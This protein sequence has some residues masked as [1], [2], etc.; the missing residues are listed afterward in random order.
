MTE[1]RERIFAV[2]WL[3]FWEIRKF[4][5]QCEVSKW[6]S[7]DQNRCQFIW[8]SLSCHL[9]VNSSIVELLVHNLIKKK[10]KEL[11]KYQLDLNQDISEQISQQVAQI[12]PKERKDELAVSKVCRRSRFGCILVS[13]WH[14]TPKR[15][16]ATFTHCRSGRPLWIYHLLMAHRRRSVST[17]VASGYIS[18]SCPQTV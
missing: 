13:S 18:H 12:E 17:A 1:S 8:Y 6:F 16:K 5:V 4:Q 14:L 15:P 7:H 2:E 10:K 9:V 11:Y 3:E